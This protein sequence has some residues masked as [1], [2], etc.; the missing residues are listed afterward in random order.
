MCPDR[1]VRQRPFLLRRLSTGGVVGALVLFSAALGP[2][3]LPRSALYQGLAAGICAAIGYVAGVAG[4]WVAVRTGLWWTPSG[5]WRRRVRWLLAGTATAVVIAALAVNRDW[6]GRSRDLLGIPRP[7][8]EQ[9]LV[10]LALALAVCLVALAATRA[11]RRLAGILARFVGRWL[12]R[13]LARLLAVVAVATGLVLLVD[14]TV[15]AGARALL[16]STYATFDTGTF[17]GDA[18]PGQPERSGSAASAS[19]WDTLGRE[20]RRFVAGGRSVEG[21]ATAIAPIGLDRPV[22]EP[23]R[24]YA[25]LAAGD[26]LADVAGVVVDELDRTGAWDRAVL[27]LATSTGTGWVDPAAADAVELLWAGDT[28]VASMQYSYL[29][30]WVTFVSDRTTP[31]AAGRALFEAVYARWS[32]LPEADRPRLYVTGVSL[33]AF[34]SQGA[35][36]SLQD[37]TARADGAVWAGTPG[38][39]PL[40]R[41]LTAGRDA[42]SPQIRPV[43]DGGAQAR[44]GLGPTEPDLWSLGPQWSSP[45]VVFLQHASDGVTWWSTDL[46]LDRP[47]WLREPR[48]PDVLDDVRWFP[49]TTFWQVTIDLLVAGDAPPGHGH[50]FTA[51]YAD[52]WAAVATPPGWTETGTQVLREAVAAARPWRP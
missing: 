6:Q 31:P 18:P 19:P 52:A 5:R 14:G 33:G 29:P 11:L 15:V 21:I 20:G 27:V 51:E 4:E 38:F 40:W 34:G 48:G 3:L 32:Q 43:L 37:L 16:T 26:T 42:G 17:A 7:D 47:D 28:A 22:R 30:S 12:P 10:V 9:P 2:S 41:D 25:G 23:I 50:N 36:S 39:T 46:L 1:P 45:R 35:F 44:W 49:V 24:V 8:S 13:V